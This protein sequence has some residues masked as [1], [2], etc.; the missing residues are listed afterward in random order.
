LWILLTYGRGKFWKLAEIVA[1]H[2]EAQTG[3]PVT[4][5]YSKQEGGELLQQ[6][7]FSVTDIR[8][9][10][11]FPYRIKEYTQ[12]RYVKEWYFRWMPEQLFHWLEHKLGWHLCITA[13][14][15]Q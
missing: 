9:E 7:G 5:T 11:I 6:A 2:S 1:R 8:V 14:L 12:Y 4:Y 13:V 3:C 15:P 10:H